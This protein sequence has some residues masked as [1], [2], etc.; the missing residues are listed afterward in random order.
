MHTPESNSGQDGQAVTTDVLLEKGRKRHFFKYF[1]IVLGL[2][3]LSLLLSRISLDEILVL[4]RQ[5]ASNWHLML[6]ACM[7]PGVGIAISSYRLQVLLQAQGVKLSIA[8]ICKANLIG[9]FYNQL[10]P[11][12]IG[13]DVV[14]GYW[15]SNARGFNNSEKVSARPIILSFT[16][17]GVDRFV[18]VI[19]VLLTGS[20]AAMV[21]PA[22]IRQSPG[23]KSVMYCALIGAAILALSPLVPARSVGRW[24]FSIPLLRNLREKAAMVYNALKEY[25][26][27]KRQLLV[28][29]ILSVCLQSCVIIQYWLL[30]NALELAVPFLS[31]AVLVPVV[32]VVS[33]L[34]LSINGIG[35]REG[36]LY[37][38]G[39][40]LGLT[41]SGSVALAYIF[42]FARMLWA[43]LGGVLHLKTPYQKT[44]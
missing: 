32:D 22:A 37:S 14:R 29:F 6:L 40:P 42:L 12:T 17:I 19:G 5:T 24:F 35:L 20:L 7:M 44:S 23:L 43:T 33:M 28:A 3:L 36:A 9:S 25:R 18:G 15:L 11:S 10:L 38:M 31:L 21:S 26:S 30:V 13:G 39:G 1:R 2:S 4:F 34:P 16:V 27:S 8:Q 41:V